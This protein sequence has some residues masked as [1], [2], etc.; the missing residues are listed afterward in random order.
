VELVQQALVDVEAITRRHYDLGPD[1]VDGKFGPM[2][3]AAVKKFKTDEGLGATR[4]PDVGPGTMRRLD[5][6]FTGAAPKPVTPVLEPGSRPGWQQMNEA[7]ATYTDP[8][9]QDLVDAIIKL[10]SNKLDALIAEL[11]ARGYTRLKKK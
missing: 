9:Q 4:Y 7:V 1:G 2:T 8:S 10:A 6:L 3:A 5:D 11:E